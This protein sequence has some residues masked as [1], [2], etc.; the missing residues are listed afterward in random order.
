M[1]KY[2]LILIFALASQLV[3][4][5]EDKFYFGD[6]N[7]FSNTNN[8]EQEKKIPLKQKQTLINFVQV[9]QQEQVFQVFTDKIFSII[10]FRQK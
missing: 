6:E 4:A 2:F 9:F 8:T 1:K 3:V 7:H 5:Q 10:M